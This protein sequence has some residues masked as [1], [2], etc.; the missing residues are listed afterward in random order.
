MATTFRKV[1]DWGN[2]QN[3]GTGIA[4]A[5]LDGN[6]RP[7]LV[8]L[9]VDAPAGANR[10]HYRVGRSLDAA[11][12]VAGGWSGWTPVP[13]WGSHENEGADI[14][15]ADLD[16]DGRPELIVLR[17][18]APAGQNQASYRIGWNLTA[19]GTV[20]GWSEWKQIPGW[21]GWLNQ[22]AGIAVA[23]L[24]GDGRPELVVLVVDAPAGKN[25]GYYKVGRALNRTGDVTAGWTGWT[26]VPDWFS[27]ENQGA[28]LAVADLDGDGRAE[29]IVFQVDNPKQGNGA[30][31]TIGWGVDAGLRP[32]DGW[33]PW[34]RL[35]DWP[36]W[37]NQGAG[38]ALADLQGSG[39]PELIVATVDNP[40][41]QNSCQYA[42][43]D[44]TTDLDTAAANGVW[45]LLDF[46]SQVL[47]VHAA[48]L[49]TGDVLFFAGSSNNPDNP[50]FRTRVWR[51]PS[52]EFRAP[53]T[54]IDL[55]CC[56]HAFLSD[57]RLLAAGGTAQYDPFQGLRDALV[58]DPGTA[59]WSA[60]PDMAGGRWYPALLT[61]PDGRILAISGL[62]ADGGLNQVPEAYTEGSGWRPLP[63]PGP[64]PMYAHLTLLRD[65]RVFYSGAHYGG[66]ND[67]QPSIWD[68]R[69]GAHTP[70]PGLTAPQMRSQ[71]ATVILPPAREQRVMVL[72]GGGHSEE[73]HHGMGGVSDVAVA[74][75]SV[76]APRYQ[77]V[78][79]LHQARMHLN[80]TLLPDRTVLATGGAQIE[81]DAAHASRHA[82]IYDPVTGRWTQGA[83]ARVPRL[84]HSVALLTP[85][86]KVITA[87]S[88]PERGQEE[89]RIEVYWPPYLFRGERPTI[90]LAADRAAYG[91]SIAATSP[92]AEQLREI[93]LV[94]PGATTHSSNNEQRL[95]D[96]PF[97]V[98]GNDAVEIDLPAEPA[99]APP[100]W[101]MVFAVSRSGVPSHAA[102]LHLGG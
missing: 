9:R 74:D 26:G 25:Q 33:G 43:L 66:N 30:Y 81:E 70:V 29:M 6:G 90:T 31:V 50:Q 95:H 83:A 84:Y 55:F 99:L 16:G 7:D 94:R 18:D 62:G 53:A 40:E 42:A 59:T 79:D 34:T 61:L 91:D 87:G 75:L 46:D 67:V 86:A 10:A 96:L 36:F 98:T 19:T 85:D 2:W 73:H 49:H 100:G 24:D 77:R 14:A 78:A 54:P 44:L 63:S 41:Q 15:V 68:I 39:R 60:A 20:S 80:A 89:M 35:P 64:W 57:G 93:N 37:E 71:G 13:D 51:Y 32:A 82:E 28:A 23:D 17:V 65:S 22:G 97:R 88:N 52:P 69:T 56:G 47:A 48:L 76:P 92:S 21:F 45:R 8:V 4:A 3:Q 101:Y 1:P 58:F 11:G 5:D 27:G 72:G 102:W 38:L 12:A